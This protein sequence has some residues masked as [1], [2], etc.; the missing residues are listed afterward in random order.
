MLTKL[1]KWIRLQQNK[2]CEP[3]L[4][5]HKILDFY[6]DDIHLYEQALLHK[7]SSREDK[8]GKWL[9]N[10]RLEFLGDA[11]LDAVVADI[12]CKHFPNKR[13]GFLTNTRA[14]IVQRESLNQ[15]ANDMGLGKIVVSSAR[16][17]SHNNYMYGNALEALIGAVYLDKGYD[18]CYLFIQDGIIQR[19]LN[20]DQIAKKEVNFKSILIE[21]SQK[22]KLE[23]TFNVLESFID[24]DGNSV[25]Q[26]GAFL[27]DTNI[28]VGTGYSKK[29]SQQIASKM[30]IRKLRSDRD[31]HLLIDEYKKK[32]K[33]ESNIEQA[34]S[35]LSEEENE[36][37]QTIVAS[38][39]CSMTK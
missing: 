27:L 39:E 30:A 25:F 15:I 10:E 8:N 38:E 7:S 34:I 19:Y 35:E 37:A 1:N 21:W 32:M 24:D 5:L 28:G 16:I 6:P 22:N 9:N 13:E 18:K 23:I 2:K 33:E 14:K 3:Y 26:T 11:I 29:E 20:L 31:L 17:S 12:V 4:S 36:T